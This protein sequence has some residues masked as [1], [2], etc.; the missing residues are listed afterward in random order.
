MAAL[1]LT[2]VGRPCGFPPGPISYG[3]GRIPHRRCRPLPL[4][5]HCLNGGSGRKDRSWG[6]DSLAASA[7]W[8]SCT[9][10][11]SQKRITRHVPRLAL[12]QTE[13][14]QALGMS[15]DAFEQHVKPCV[16][17]VYAGSRR[18]YPVAGL[19]RW[20]AEESVRAGRRAA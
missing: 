7:R 16:A 20:L 19:E 11:A 6:C 8:R 17:C 13:A 10:M 1:P 18:L 14:A 2:A 9:R 5:F 4:S 3:A 15:V 12:N